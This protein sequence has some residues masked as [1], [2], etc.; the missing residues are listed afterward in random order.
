[1]VS[2][3]LTWIEFLDGAANTGTADTKYNN[4]NNSNDFFNTFPP[5]F[6]KYSLYSQQKNWQ[7][8]IPL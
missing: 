2:E 5:F 3:P 6:S 8:K 7:E 4:I 1:M